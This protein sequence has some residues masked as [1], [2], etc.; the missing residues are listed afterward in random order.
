MPEQAGVV[1]AFDFGLKRIGVAMGELMLGEARALA[2]IDEEA[3]VPRFAKIEKL[4]GQWQPVQL[5]V[6]LPLDVEGREHDMSA[7][8]RRFANQ[9]QGRFKL[10]VSLVDERYTS[11][12]AEAELKQQG[13]HWTDTKAQVDATAARI[14]LQSYFDD[15]ARR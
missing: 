6:G 5:V 10:P 3:N 12:E 13:G 15:P 9:L 7:R 11:V 1:L 8:A 2:T 14:I 4:I